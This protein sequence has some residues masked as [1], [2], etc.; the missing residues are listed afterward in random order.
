MERQKA[1]VMLREELNKHNLTNW[2]AA[3]VPN[4]KIAGMCIYKEKKIVL[5]SFHVDCMPEL[6][7]RDTILH[8][9]AHILTP[10]CGHN[11]IW[12][13]KATELGAKPRACSDYANDPRVLDAI[14]SGAQVEMSTVEEVIQRPVFRVT[15]LQDKCEKCDKVAVTKSE[16]FFLNPNDEL[17]DTKVIFL[18]CGH[19]VVKKLPKGT[20]FH[21][22][23]SDEKIHKNCKHNW[24]KNLCVECG[25]FG[26]F[27]FQI[28]GMK[29]IEQ[30]LATNKGAAVFDEMGLGKTIQALGYIKYHPENWPVLYVVKS[31]IKFQWYQQILTWL[32]EEFI[33]QV[34]NG[35]NDY[36]IPG[37]RTYIISYDML[38]PK[39][40]TSK[41]GKVIQ[42]GF[43]PQR[44]IDAGIKLMVLDE[45]QQIKNPDSSRTQQVRKL[46]RHMNVI[47]LSG[48]PWKNRGSELFSV[49]NMIAPM[50]FS[51]YQGFLDKWVDYYMDGSYQKMGGI[52]KP[53]LFK[54]Y[55]KDIAI[56]R[57]RVEVM[58][59]LPLV[60][61]T[62]LPVELN[63]IEQSEYDEAESAFAKWYNDLVIGGEQPTGM[64]MLAQMARMRHLS[65]LAKIPA[66]LEF[67]EEYY[68]NTDRKMVIFA[69]HR[70]VQEII[71]EELKNKYGGVVKVLQLTGA[72]NSVDR[73]SIQE[74]FNK[75]ERAFMVASTLAAG[76]GLN[77]QTC[78]DCI[79][80]ERQWNPA[81]EEQAEGRFIRIGQTATSVNGTYIQQVGSIDADLASIVDRK[82]IQ[83]HA[84][85][86]KSEMTQ[87]NQ[88]DLVKE[89]AERIVA[90]VRS[91][92]KAA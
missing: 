23:V 26:P 5:S 18:E 63:P 72:Q 68:E 92:A 82:R 66:T 52:R 6:E 1:F 80:H 65:G 50:K 88:S 77:L 57:E 48:S 85:M 7:V 90:R 49:L 25:G 83:F 67:M 39:T 51:S 40:R 20:P 87:W 15:R 46:A 81:N 29:F 17:P 13:A 44:L 11:E 10:G 60:N 42:Q 8:E 9:I 78:A 79:M 54:E 47:A 31:G 32:G 21:R 28:E 34:I 22:M 2:K 37:F 16:Q 4:D 64:S 45:C 84:A 75:S 58:K 91:K 35:S 74:D 24:D 73:F 62:Q 55:I 76:E 14:R 33:G 70:D 59:E 53:E 56:R 86:N 36:I 41:K 3:L 27:K 71:F 89:V 43:D 12:Q 61:R 38:I 30:A 19:V 69:H